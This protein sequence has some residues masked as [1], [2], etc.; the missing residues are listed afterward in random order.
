MIGIYHGY[1]KP[2]DANSFLFDFIEE[3]IILTNSEFLINEHLYHLQI[4]SFICDAPAKAFIKCKKHHTGYHSCTKCHIEGDYIDKRVCFPDVNNI[5]LRTDVEFRSKVDEDHHAGTTLLENIPGIDMINSFP[6]DYM[7]LICFGVMKKLLLNLWCCGK[8]TTKISHSKFLNIS[9]CLVSL[10]KCMPLE[11]N[12]KPRSLNDLKRWKATEF[13]QFLFYTGPVVLLNNISKDQYTNFLSLHVAT[14]I[15]SNSKYFTLIDYASE[16]L[17]YFVKTFKILYGEQ[18]ISHNVHNLL[19]I[20]EDVRNHGPLHDF[21]AFH[22]ENSFQTILT[23]IRTRD[24][25][26]EQIV[27]RHSEKCHIFN[28]KKMHSSKFPIFKNEHFDGPLIRNVTASKQFKRV[29]FHH[30]SLK[31]SEPNN[32]CSLVNGDIILVQK[33]ILS[34]DVYKIVGRKFLYLKDFYESPCKSS[35]FGIFS[36]ES[37]SLGPSEIFNVTDIFAKYIKLEMNEKIIVF[38]LLHCLS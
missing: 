28:K 15:L 19:H 3:A 7:H 20:A 5:K 9:N 18:H 26:L 12:R 32:C 10:A 16:L 34:G 6:L 35:E 2:K 31:T 22:F 23:S 29:D 17:N 37:P 36:I 14:I 30:F 24:K 27:K 38:P 4:K 33:V 1:E 11:F 8:P 25:I 13:R 21:G